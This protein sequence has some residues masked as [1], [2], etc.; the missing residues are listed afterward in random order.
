MPPILYYSNRDIKKI[1]NGSII[2]TQYENLYIIINMLDIRSVNRFRRVCKDCDW[3]SQRYLTNLIYDKSKLFVIKEE[4]IPIYNP[5]NYAIK[6]TTS[7]SNTSSYIQ[8]LLSWGPTLWNNISVCMRNKDIDKAKNKGIVQPIYNKRIY[9]RLPSLE[10]LKLYPSLKRILIPLV[11]PT[12]NIYKNSEEEKSIV[13]LKALEDELL[14][15]CNK[16]SE[17]YNTINSITIPYI[18]G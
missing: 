4:D 6:N 9:L 18:M 8:F 13:K 1:R 14:A 17:E 7:I 5:R 2:L 3:L 10:I 12:N 15:K 16:L 11:A